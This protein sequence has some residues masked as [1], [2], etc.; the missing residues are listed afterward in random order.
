MLGRAGPS[1]CRSNLYY[2]ELRALIILLY[3]RLAP[4]SAYKLD[5]NATLST[6][7]VAIETV[8]L[9]KLLQAIPGPKKLL[10]QLPVSATCYVYT[11]HR[12]VY[13]LAKV[14]LQC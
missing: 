9:L 10:Q 8:P 5:I 3:L 13:N 14:A 1:E 4:C 7:P 11:K 2:K 6:D 12:V